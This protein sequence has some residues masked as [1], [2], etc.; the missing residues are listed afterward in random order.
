MRE[1]KITKAKLRKRQTHFNAIPRTLQGKEN[2]IW[3]KGVRTPWEK[4]SKFA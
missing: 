2:Q 3:E 4:I 1:R